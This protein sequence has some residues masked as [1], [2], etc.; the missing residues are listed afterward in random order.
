MRHILLA[1]AAMTLAACSNDMEPTGGER[2]PDG[3]YPLNITATVEG[4]TSRAGG[5]STEFQAGDA[6]GVRIGDATETTGKYVMDE[7]GAWVAET[8]LYWQTSADA[9]ITAWYPCEAAPVNLADQSKDFTPVDFLWAETTASYLDNPLRITFRHRMAKV[10]YVLKNEAGISEAD[11]QNVK[12][13]I[14]GYTFVASDADGNLTG[15]AEDWITPGAIETWLYPQEMTGK[16]L[17]RVT[18]KIDGQNK[19]FAYTPADEADGN[20]TP[21][22]I[23]TYTITVKRDRI[24]VEKV[25]GGEWNPGENE[26]ISSKEVEATYTADQLKPGDFFYRTAEGKWDTSDGGLRAIYTDG[27]TKVED[28]TVDAKKGTCIGIVFRAERDP[29]DDSD[30][31]QQ[32]TANTKKLSG[33]VQGYVVALT[34][35]DCDGK[36]WERD[37]LGKWGILIGTSTSETDWNGYDNNCKI[38]QKAI[39]TQGYGV[40]NWPAYEACVEYGTKDWHNGLYSPTDTS[41]WYLPSTGQFSEILKFENLIARNIDNVK[42]STNTAAYKDRLNWIDYNFDGYFL[43]W[44]SN[45]FHSG[46]ATAAWVYMTSLHKL[47]GIEK[48]AWNYADRQTKARCVLTF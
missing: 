6:I 32:I 8:P 31:T 15:S 16:Q 34:D 18:A 25:T 5:E 28:M 23:H 36:G 3:K 22:C 40:S 13:K 24:V 39:S 26:N 12:V 46:S 37:P 7:N 48:E 43:Y 11:L 35:A 33:D 10:K 29:N 14:Y 30:Y 38:Y 9:T 42:Q 47:G 41:L 21:G 45:E 2:L 27:S 44:L 17:I 4:M 1:A 19:T 20:I